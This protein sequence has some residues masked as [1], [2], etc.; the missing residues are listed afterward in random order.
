MCARACTYAQV[1]MLGV[2][3]NPS[4]PYALRR[5]L[6]LN[7]ALTNVATLAGRQTLEICLS[8]PPQLG[9]YT[10]TARGFLIGVLR[11]KLGSSC[12]WDSHST[13]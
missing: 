4:S 6:S 1:L 11:I 5:D 2:F 8:L 7:L 3:F 10:C 12:L 9:D 13:H